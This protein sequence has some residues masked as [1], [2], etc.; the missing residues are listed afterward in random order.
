M[1]VQGFNVQFKSRLNQ[2]KKMKREKNKT[3]N[4]KTD[5]QLLSPEMVIKIREIHPKGEGDYGG[6]DLRKR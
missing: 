4:G 3:K 5:E 2:Q 1:K 6:K